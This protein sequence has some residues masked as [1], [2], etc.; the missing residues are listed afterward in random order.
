MQNEVI[1]KLKLEKQYKLLGELVPELEVVDQWFPGERVTFEKLRGKVIFLDFWAHGCAPC[2]EAFPTI[3][4]LY[5]DHKDQGLVILG[6]TLLRCS[7]WNAG[8]QS[9]EIEF[10]KRFKSYN[11]PYDFIVT[12]DQTTQRAFETTTCQPRF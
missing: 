6:I 10:V 12:K 3:R 7:R 8:R 11:L 1:Q 2:I 5:A 4:E 9:S